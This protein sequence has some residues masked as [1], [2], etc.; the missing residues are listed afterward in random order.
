MVVKNEVGQILLQREVLAEVREADD[1]M[2]PTDSPTGA[3]VLKLEETGKKLYLPAGRNRPNENI[4]EGRDRKL[5]AETGLTGI[6]F[7]LVA[8]RFEGHWLEIIWWAPV[9]SCDFDSGR[10]R[11][12]EGCVWMD[13]IGAIQALD[14]FK[15]GVASA[16]DRQ[17]WAKIRFWDVGVIVKA[18][19]SNIP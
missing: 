14:R 3:G 6:P 19:L 10:H 4:H 15:E 16:E 9:R 17:F 12:T 5:L 8:V 2:P 13:Q 7:D 1:V 11:L 18:S